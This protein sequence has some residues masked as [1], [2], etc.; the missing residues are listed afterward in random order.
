MNRREALATIGATGLCPTTAMAIP[1]NH[2]E[3]DYSSACDYI[4]WCYS[5]QTF[6]ITEKQEKVAAWLKEKIQ[7][8]Q[9]THS[10]NE[11]LNWLWGHY[12]E[13]EN[14]NPDNLPVLEFDERG[15]PKYFKELR[16]RATVFENGYE[17][18]RI[19]VWVRKE[20]AVNC[21][22]YGNFWGELFLYFTGNNMMLNCAE[23]SIRDH[24]RS[25]Y[26]VGIDEY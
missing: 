17:T 13:P 19:K 3:K 21:T 6:V 16:Q 23:N 9:K 5:G 24:G 25:H 12:P 11:C 8:Y 4:A 26:W 7:V 22:V 14:E 10:H 2:N 15:V 1:E 18:R 20:D